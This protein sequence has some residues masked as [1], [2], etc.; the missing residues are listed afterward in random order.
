MSE[1]A[2]KRLQEGAW[3]NEQRD[4]EDPGPRATRFKEKSTVFPAMSWMGGQ[5][6]E[7][8]PPSLRTAC[9]GVVAWQKKRCRNVKE[10]KEVERL[11]DKENFGIVGLKDGAGPRQEWNWWNRRQSQH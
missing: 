5:E 7:P 1:R 2:R 6:G 4:C 8:R 3:I 9:G 10:A 11:C